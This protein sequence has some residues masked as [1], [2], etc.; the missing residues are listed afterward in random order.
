MPTPPKMP[1]HLQ[2]N[3][4]QDVAD[5]LYRLVV[6]EEN[7]DAYRHDMALLLNLSAAYRLSQITAGHRTPSTQTTAA[8]TS[9]W[10]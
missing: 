7:A 9:R 4:L 2:I 6:N 3:R 10:C 8:F 5:R 1:G